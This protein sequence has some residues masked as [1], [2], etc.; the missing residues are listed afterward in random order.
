MKFTYVSIVAV[1]F[2]VIAVAAAGCASTSPSSSNSAQASGAP[3]SGTTSPSAAS[4]SSPQVGST[5]SASS[6][7]STNYNWMEYQTSA[8]YNGKQSTM[9]MKYE[10]ST[11]D[12]QGSP[13]VH[14]ELTMTSSS[15]GGTNSV[16]DYYWDTAMDKLLG[17]TMTMTVN[18]K[19]MT[20]SI[21]AE[22]LTQAQATNFHTGT[23][24]FA[25]VESVTVPAGTYPAASK[26]TE[27]TNGVDVTFWSAPG[28]PVPV[29]MA[30]SSSSGSSTSE[31]VGYG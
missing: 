1:M 21:P 6:I 27:T 26:Y 15:N 9:D 13:A 30:S 20:I 29:K 3:S 5:S 8:N 11:G 24:T 17:G 10:R 16:I 23:L 7:F 2:V 22:E 14:V 28:V 4:S 19:T 25:G 18:G 12:Y 31:L